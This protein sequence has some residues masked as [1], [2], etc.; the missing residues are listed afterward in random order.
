MVEFVSCWQ[1]WSGGP[2]DPALRVQPQRTNLFVQAQR[3]NLFVFVVV[4]IDLSDLSEWL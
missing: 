2:V 4:E 1:N 3:T